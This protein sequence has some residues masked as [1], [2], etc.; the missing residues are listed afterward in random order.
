MSP[1]VRRKLLLKG[2]E[3]CYTDSLG[4]HFPRLSGRYLK[5]F[6]LGLDKSLNRLY[7]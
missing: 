7:N 1:H 6:H 4:E 2:R 3:V 5:I